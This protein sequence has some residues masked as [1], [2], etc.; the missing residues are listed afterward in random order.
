MLK[1]PTKSIGTPGNGFPNQGKI[2]K[3]PTKFVAPQE[4]GS[5][6]EVES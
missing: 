3:K 2:L 6:I 5:Q 4:M 1:R